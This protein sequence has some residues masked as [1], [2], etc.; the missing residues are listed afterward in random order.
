MKG[1]KRKSWWRS[2]VCWLFVVDVWSGYNFQNLK[3]CT[4]ILYAKCK[5]FIASQSIILR[6]MTGIC[7]QTF[8]IR[9]CVDSA[10]VSHSALVNHSNSGLVQLCITPTLH[11]LL[12]LG[13]NYANSRPILLVQSTISFHLVSFERVCSVP[14]SY[15]DYWRRCWGYQNDSIDIG[16]RRAA[17]ITHHT[18]T[19]NTSTMTNPGTNHGIIGSKHPIST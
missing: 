16:R 10:L 1:G 13:H 9:L 8:D 6:G 2:L 15:S 5:K 19:K 12:T 3:I 18:L 11:L 14:C 7:I 17:A 4:L